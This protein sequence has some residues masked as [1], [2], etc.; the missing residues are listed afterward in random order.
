MNTKDS[1][2]TVKTISETAIMAALIC[3]LG[4]LSVPIGPV[5]VSLTPFAIFLTVCILGQ[6]KGTAAVCIYLLL[7]AVG[8]PVFTGWQGGL[9]KLAGP[10]GGYL[11]GY[12]ATCVPS[13]CD[14]A[15][16]CSPQF[17]VEG[18]GSVYPCDFYC[19]DEKRLG[20]LND[21]SFAQ[22][23]FST[24]VYLPIYNSGISVIIS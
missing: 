9:A 15:G 4:P 24:A 12:L 19:L 20:N 3:V 22:M 8:L 21:L 6:K 2:I 17:V 13:T 1:S 5:P 16:H 14:V 11:I 18:D 23:C 10:T 7:G